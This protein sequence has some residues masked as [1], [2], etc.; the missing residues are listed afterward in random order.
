MTDFFHQAFTKIKI[1][2]YE[3]DAPEK[4]LLLNLLPVQPYRDQCVGV[5]AGFFSKKYPDSLIIDVGANIGDT[6]AIVSTYSNNEL[7]LIESSDYYFDILEA[8]SS[9]FKN[10]VTLK[11]IFIADGS[12]VSGYLYHWGGTAY[13][14]AEENGVNIKTER[15]CDL[16]KNKVCFVKLDTDGFDFDIILDSVKWF[17]Q[18]KPGILFENQIRNAHD[19]AQADLVFDKLFEIGYTH[20]I[21]WDDPGFHL[22]STSSIKDLKQL[23][24]YLFKVWER[25]GYRTICN[26][27]VLCI[28]ENDHEIYDSLCKY[29]ENY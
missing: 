28:H 4:H 2:D 23:N 14:K 3:I 16:T 17:S 9:K 22:L 12:Q 19:L 20:F 25:E 11:K 27:D 6:A 24:R 13:F 1:G 5:S 21:V 7:L 15:L 8:N 18:V 29:Y 10:N 26:Y